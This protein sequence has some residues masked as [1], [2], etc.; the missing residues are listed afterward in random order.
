MKLIDFFSDR[1]YEYVMYYLAIL[2][3]RE[4]IFLLTKQ[5]LHPLM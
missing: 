4:C 1:T 5:L 3:K 2:L